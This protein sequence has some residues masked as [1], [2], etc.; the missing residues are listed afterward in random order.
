MVN[1]ELLLACINATSNR[2]FVSPQSQA[3]DVWTLYDVLAAE[4]FKRNQEA[5]G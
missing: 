3:S 2:F 1:D 5:N 4:R